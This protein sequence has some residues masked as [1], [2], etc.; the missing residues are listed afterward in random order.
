MRDHAD[1]AVLL[2]HRH[3]HVRDIRNPV[4]SERGEQ[5][6][7]RHALA[8]E[9]RVQH[10]TVVH[11]DRRLGFDEKKSLGEKETGARAAL[12]IWIDF[13]TA[14][15]KGHDQDEFPI[16]PDAQKKAAVATAKKLDTP[17]YQ[18]GDG[19]AH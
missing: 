10:L 2:E 4:A 18:P 5:I 1:P 6:V 16:S 15:I 7:H 17:D 9:V 3:A 11:E 19:E 12:P 13:M 8:R 14:A